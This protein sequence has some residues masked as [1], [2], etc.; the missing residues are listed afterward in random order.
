MIM[1]MAAF[2]VFAEDEEGNESEEEKSEFATGFFNFEEES[3][4]AVDNGQFDSFETKVSTLEGGVNLNLH[5]MITLSPY[6]GASDVKFSV[7]ETP[8]VTITNPGIGVA[9]PTFNWDEAT[10]YTGLKL[11]LVPVDFLEISLALYNTNTFEPDW[12]YA[13]LGFSLGF[14]FNI[15]K[16]FLEISLSDDLEPTWAAKPA[17]AAER[18]AVFTKLFNKFKYGLRFN[19]FNFIRDDL[20]TGLFA[21]GKLETTSKF[22][23]GDENDKD[24]QGTEL[25]NE[26]FIGLATNP[27]EWFECYAAFAMFNENNYAPKT[28]IAGKD[29]KIAALTNDFG[30]KLGV[31][32][33]YKCVSFDLNWVGRNG[34]YAI[35]VDLLDKETK[36]DWGDSDNL[37]HELTFTVGVAL[38]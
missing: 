30:I 28:E 16:A 7:G 36:W 23:D 29:V 24:Y 3:V 21:E 11:A 31:K 35:A 5:E 37:K 17:I 10:V 15:E 8:V 26:F 38:E 19:F 4:L 27:I 33:F 34:R 12:A 9:S 13:G 20:N 14:G 32:F 2:G 22:G 18:T 1:M 25:K 6:A